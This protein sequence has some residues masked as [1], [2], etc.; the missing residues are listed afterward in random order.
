MACR[1]ERRRRRPGSRNGLSRR[2][3]FFLHH[4]AEEVSGGGLAPAALCRSASH[5]LPD[6]LRQDKRLV[7][8]TVLRFF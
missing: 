8:L 7:L 6:V 5:Y 2:H 4:V 1:P 3:R